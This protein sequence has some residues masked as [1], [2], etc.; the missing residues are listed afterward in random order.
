MRPARRDWNINSRGPFANRA[1]NRSH[2][3]KRLRTT[4]A[5]VLL[6]GTVAF[7]QTTSNTGGTAPNIGGVANPST[8]S[9]SATVGAPPSANPSNPQDLTTR[10]NPQDLIKSGASNP[11]NLTRPAK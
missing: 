5:L 2:V 4:M 3:M 7:A 9:N 6:S 8:P 1:S 10:S 11:Q